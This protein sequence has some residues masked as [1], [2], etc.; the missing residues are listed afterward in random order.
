MTDF[1]P[2]LFILGLFLSAL[3]VA[4]M[5]PALVDAAIGHDDWRVFALSG[6]ATLFVG[7]ALATGFRGD[8]MRLDLRQGFVLTAATWIVL[9]AFSALPFVFSDITLSYVDAYFEAVSGLTTTGATVLV[10]LE[11][12]PPGILLWRSIL[13]FIGGAGIIVMAIAV[14]P[15]L[16]VGGMQLFRAE[17]SEKSDKVLPRLS[18]VAAA[19][20]AVYVG[21]TALC[22]ILYGVAGMSGFDAVTHAMTTVST[23]GFANY[24]SS[25]AWFQNPAIEWIAILF[26]LIGG[27]PMVVFILLAR[28]HFRP[29]WSDSQIRAFLAIVLLASLAMTLWLHATRD[30]EFGIALRL[31]LFNVTS[32][33]TTTGYA[34]ADYGT[35]GGFAMV[36]FVL[37]MCVGGCTGSTTGAIKVFRLQILARLIG[38]QL[39]RQMQPH[40]VFPMHYMGQ[41]VHDD[42]QASVMAFFAVYIVSLASLTLVLAALGY[43]LV[44]AFSGAASILSNHGPGLGD[45]IGP[46]GNFQ[47]LSDAAKWVL[48]FG[49]FLGR[50]EIFTLLML[51]SVRLWRG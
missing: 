39:R 23:A 33:T 4:M 14:L 3:A 12:M 36:G 34:S 48:C 11:S 18:S 32:V 1:R 10:G 26:M 51:F 42:V 15:F 2:V 27:C 17:S 38:A 24:D 13:Q 31:A 7:V 20:V 22:A 47:S 6:A 29:L 5:V 25:F 28:G 40:G 44:T 16:R 30:V 8:A 45:I 46:S 41:H 37:L 19:T 50:L 43:D 49:M 9:S 35:W 21:L